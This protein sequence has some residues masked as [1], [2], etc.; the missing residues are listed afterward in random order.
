MRLNELS[1]IN[2]GEMEKEKPKR[3]YLLNDEIWSAWQWVG[4]RENAHQ[5]AIEPLT[6][7]KSMD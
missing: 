5:N 2:D 3:N 1:R 7:D 6:V 4:A